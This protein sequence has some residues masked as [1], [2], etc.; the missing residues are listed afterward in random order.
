MLG[1]SQSPY[2]FLSTI[3]TWKQYISLDLSTALNPATH[4]F[5]SKI[6]VLNGVGGT[7]K[8]SE[9]WGKVSYPSGFGERSG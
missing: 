8:E 3:A 1:R 7:L 5:P 2:C 9:D 4:I 6:V